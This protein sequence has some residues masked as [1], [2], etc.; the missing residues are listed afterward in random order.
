M[1]HVFAINNIICDMLGVS[2]KFKPKISSNSSSSLHEIKS[3]K[4]MSSM[5][6]WDV[7]WYQLDH[8]NFKDWLEN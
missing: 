6:L 2:H 4:Q 7:E 5:N 1:L 8:K 3:L